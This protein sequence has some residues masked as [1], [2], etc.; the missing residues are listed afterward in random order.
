MRRLLDPNLNRTVAA[1]SATIAVLTAVLGACA[2]VPTPLQGQ[3]DPVTPREAAASGGSGPAVR[4][5]GEII[6]VAPQENR[7]CFEILARELDSTAR[8]IKRDPSAGRFMACRGGFYDPEEFQHGREVTVVGHL[9]GVERGMVGQFDYTYPRV[10]ADAIYLWP[11]RPLYT[12]YYD[13]WYGDP[14]WWGAGPYW[15]PY[16]G[17]PYWGGGVIVRPHASSAPA[18]QPK[19]GN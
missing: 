8:P 15:G 9:D 12:P 17:G 2:S 13:P 18:P 3:F 6:K 14:F 5:G 16:W 11:K 4:W 10:A 7:T 19:P 1:K